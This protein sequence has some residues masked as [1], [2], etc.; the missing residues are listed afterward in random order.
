MKSKYIVLAAFIMFACFTA[1]AQSGRKSV[2]PNEPQTQTEEKQTDKKD[3]KRGEIQPVKIF[4]RPAPDASVAAYCFRKEGFDFVKT[5][6]RLTFD[7][8]AKITEVEVKTASGCNAFDA[9]SV[10]AAR[11]IKFE[12]AVQNGKPITVTKTVVY[13]GGIH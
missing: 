7:A 5:V 8:T 6:L 4:R 10:D 3:E 1:N 11:R 13:Q 2:Q 9:E 12:P